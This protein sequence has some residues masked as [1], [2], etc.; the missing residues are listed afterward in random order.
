MI[1]AGIDEAGRGALAGPVV[2]AAVVLPDLFPRD[3]LDDSKKLSDKKRRT[4]CDL[5]RRSCDWGVGIVPAE[6]V[7]EI[8]IKRATRKAMWEAI[9]QLR[10][11]PEKLQVDGRDGF[12]FPIPSEDF[13]HGDV[14]ISEIS[15]ASIVAKVVRDDLMIDF[16]R[17]FPAFDFV[18]NK[19]Y[20]SEFHL[21]L[22]EQRKFTPEHRKTYEPLRTHLVQP[23]LFSDF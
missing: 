11:R 18:R 14:H 19:G 20:G 17:Q 10:F 21:R 12:L 22:L 6:E 8:G 5:I 13:V 1:I 7:D 16:G 2:A 4:A 9:Q 15:A 3:T 23:R